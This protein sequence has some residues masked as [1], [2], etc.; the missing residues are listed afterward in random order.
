MVKRKYIDPVPLEEWIHSPWKDSTNAS[1][2]WKVTIVSF[3]LV[4]EG[5]AWQVGNGEKI[6]LGIDPW[7]GCN[8]TFALSRGV[9]E[10]MHSKVSS[11]CTR[12]QSRR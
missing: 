5:L 4:E 10:F 1:V 6:R 9:S 8:E 2:I 7:V 11:T 3:K 12:L